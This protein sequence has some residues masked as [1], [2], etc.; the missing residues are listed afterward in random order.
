MEGGQWV[1]GMPRARAHIIGDSD[2]AAGSTV[3]S[4]DG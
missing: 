1:I 3:F 2:G 4:M